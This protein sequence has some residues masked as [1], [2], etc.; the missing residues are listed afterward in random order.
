[1]K[2]KFLGESSP[3]MLINGKSYDVISIEDGWY[4]IVD[5][6]DEDDEKAEGRQALTGRAGRA[7]ETTPGPITFRAPT[8]DYDDIY[9]RGGCPVRF[10]AYT[11]D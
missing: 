4:R 11:F 6:T 2:V 3:L 7:V 10:F 5:E 8:S 9:K 1:M